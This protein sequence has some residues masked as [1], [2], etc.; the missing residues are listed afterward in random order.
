MG[1]SSR[2][3]K[4][5]QHSSINPSVDEQACTF[6]RKCMQW[7]PVNAII[8]EKKKAFILTDTCI[9]CGECL[10]LC[11]YDA[12]RYDWGIESADLQKGVAEHALGVVLNKQQRCYFF[13]FLIDMTKGC[14]CERVRQ[15]RIMP[16]V[17]IL[18]SHDPVAIDR[19][20]LDL[21]AKRHG[22]TLSQKS[23]PELNPEIQLEHAEKI[24]LGN[25][26]YA[27]EIL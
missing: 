13:N 22:E 6:C 26:T 18:A 3:G 19:A 9:G 2:M 24:G 23:E 20:T 16:D 14:D 4:L 25:R 1:L 15:E 12:I 5:R 11:N 7:C 27:L 10:S 8:E 17:G 21:T